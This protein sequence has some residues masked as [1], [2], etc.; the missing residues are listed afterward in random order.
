[1]RYTLFAVILLCL[2]HITPAFAQN[3]STRL[4]AGVLV[5]KRGLTQTLTIKG[6]D[7]EKMPFTDLGSALGA[8]M[9]GAYTNYN[10]ITYVV[11]GNIVS[12]V[13]MYSIY[14]IEEVVLVQNAAVQANLPGGMQQLALITTKKG[15]KGKLGLD[16]AAQG[17]V[18]TASDHTS[19]IYQQYYIRGYGNSRNMSYGLSVDGQRDVLPSMKE[20]GTHVITPDGLD[21]LRLNGFFTVRA[22]DKNTIEVHVGYAPQKKDSAKTFPSYYQ[23]A[24]SMKINGNDHQHN[25]VPW[26][27]WHGE[28]LPGLSN[29][30]Q[31]G[32]LSGLEKGTLRNGNIFS[33]T[34][35][36]TATYST[37]HAHMDHLYIRDRLSYRAHAGGWT[38]EPS[39]N[40]SYEHL[41]DL[42]EWIQSTVDDPAGVSGVGSGSGLYSTNESEQ[43]YKTK[44]YVLTP[45]V[46][47]G[48]KNFFDL[49]GGVLTN[50]SHAPGLSF[51]RRLYPYAT[52]SLD[53][54]HWLKAESCTGLTVFGSYAERDAMTIQDY[55]LLDLSRGST[56]GLLNQFMGGGLDGGS[57]LGT[58]G[59]GIAIASPMP[60][61]RLWTWS[62]GTRLSLCKDRLVLNYHFERYNGLDLDEMVF[63]GGGVYYQFIKETGTLHNGSIS[64]RVT[65][66]K[67][68]SWQTGIN[69]TVL[70]HKAPDLFGGYSIS[71][72]LGD[73]NMKHSSW[74]GGW[75]NRLGYKD[76]SLGVDMQYH[77]SELVPG[78]SANLVRHNSFLMQ[79]LYAGY[80]LH[81]AK[82]RLVDVYVNARNL[83]QGKSSTLADQY[84]YYGVGG[85]LAI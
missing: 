62:M 25:F 3:D 81:L 14:D 42:G 82:G 11:D 22:G 43:W 16:A 56:L 40:F 10:T 12:D 52:L 1:M 4:D 73:Y 38:I 63:P 74:T 47:F 76:F 24:T 67:D 17:G 54:L 59:S 20:A 35:G 48:Y 83:V 78:S 50:I 39:L 61:T 85:K 34:V 71:S 41:N 33:A 21:R 64:A 65:N 13:N 69:T 23:P 58:I 15:G 26:A 46:D 79:E 66:G 6:T 75:V 68:F 2:C 27:R 7:L 84:K 5:L 9:Y 19:N 44:I 70:T 77:F 55:G 45:T 32:Y 72:S 30:L 60:D 49:Q 37:G 53:I 8:W 51:G 28:W 36:D 29:D 80:K 31:V 57:S 18:V